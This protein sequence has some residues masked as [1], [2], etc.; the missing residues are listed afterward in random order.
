[1]DTVLQSQRLRLRSLRRTDAKVLSQLVGQSIIACMTSSIPSPFDQRSAEGYIDIARARHACGH[2]FSWAVTHQQKL[3]G[4]AAIFRGQTGWE[5]GYWIAPD[6]W[7]Q[8][9]GR[10]VVNA[11]VKAFA[12]D[13]PGQDLHAHVFTDNPISR[14]LLL[15]AGFEQVLEDVKGYSIARDETVP[16]W[17]FRWSSSD[18][19]Q[20]TV[21]KRRQFDTANAAVPA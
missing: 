9:F 19:K 8:G 21:Q 3:I 7:N 10:E 20:D 1:M 5:I 16:M 13:F 14:T 11:L 6:H 12:K 4:G 17:S 2:S 18:M 15:K